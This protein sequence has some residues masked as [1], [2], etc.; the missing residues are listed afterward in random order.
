MVVRLAWAFGEGVLFCDYWLQATRSRPFTKS[1][2]RCAG[3]P[4][5]SLAAVY[6]RLAML[7]E[8]D[9]VLILASWDG[10]KHYDCRTPYSHLHVMCLQ[11]G[12]I[13]DVELLAFEDA[14]EHGAERNGFQITRHRLDSFGICARCRQDT[15]PA[16]GGA[17]DSITERRGA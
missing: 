1:M 14:S 8:I 17:G 9:E 5:T 12:R 6:A 13:A 2:T 11:C 3:T 7:E 16:L 4:A 10:S 15:V